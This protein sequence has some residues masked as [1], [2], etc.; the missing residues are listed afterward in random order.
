MNPAVDVS[1][2]VSKIAPFTKL[3]CAPAHQDPGGGGINVARVVTRLGGEAAAIYA[4]GGATGQLLRR[5]MD[6]KEYGALRSR[7]RR[8]LGRISRFSRRRQNSST[9]LSCQVLRSVSR[10][11]RNASGC[12]R[13]PNLVRNLSLQAAACH[14]AYPRIFLAESLALQRRWLPRQSWTRPVHLSNLL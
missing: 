1:T 7:P 14:R 5:L 13:A 6:E 4:A 8:K 2:S 11:G 9:V 10:S 12:L 3:H